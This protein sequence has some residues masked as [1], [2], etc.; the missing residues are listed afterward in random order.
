M[1]ILTAIV[2]ALF[3]G[4]T[5]TG[6]DYGPF[7]PNDFA[8]FHQASDEV[9]SA[10]DDQGKLR[11]IYAK[12]GVRNEDGWGRVCQAF[13]A[14]N[15]HN[16]D[17]HVVAINNRVQEQLDNMGEH[18]AFPMEYLAPVE[19]VGMDRLA[20]IVA[21]REAASGPAEVAQMLGSYG[22]DDAKF[23]RIEAGWNAR[24]GGSADAMAAGIISGFWHTYLAVAR[25]AMKQAA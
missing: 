7:D 22:L 9:S 12:Y 17:F 1:S 19:G 5:P 3:G 4:S 14:A 10:D 18:Y 8:R 24:M 21:R 2:N 13:Y 11:E 20:A 25:S 23:R 15:K 6:P 16:P